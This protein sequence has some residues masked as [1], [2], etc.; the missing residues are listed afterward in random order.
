MQNPFT[1]FVL[2]IVAIFQW[3]LL[4]L[5]FILSGA[6][7]SQKMADAFFAET[8]AVCRA[9][10]QVARDFLDAHD[11]NVTE[12]HKAMSPEAADAIDVLRA[13][14][15]VQ[16]TELQ[17]QADAIHSSVGSNAKG[18]ALIGARLVERFAGMPPGALQGHLDDAEAII[19]GRIDDVAGE[20]DNVADL[21]K[22]SITTVVA[23]NLAKLNAL[24]LD[25][26]AYRAELERQVLEAKGEIKDIDKLTTDEL[27]RLIGLTGAGI[28]GGG[29]L[30]KTGKS[31]STKEILTLQDR[32][33][34]LTD[35]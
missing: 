13:E 16:R 19:T 31:R 29:V 23:D 24:A 32:V 12:Q 5:F 8:V 18:L 22:D 34:A 28:I 7:C 27:L 14:F 25:R 30:G 35:K 20:V 26:V 6:G 4:S 11:E 3:L 2:G 9:A 21:T 33:D 10:H 15:A 1:Q 17:A